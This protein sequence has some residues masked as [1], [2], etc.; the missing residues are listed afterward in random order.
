[1]ATPTAINV[2]RYVCGCKTTFMLLSGNS[3]RLLFGKNSKWKEF[4][5]TNSLFSVIKKMVSSFPP[6]AVPNW[7]HKLKNGAY[8]SNKI[9]ERC[10]LSSMSDGM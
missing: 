3:K 5:A 6:S 10:L 2:A 4:T 9:L 8:V 7:M 1:M